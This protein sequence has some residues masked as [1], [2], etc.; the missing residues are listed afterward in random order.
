VDTLIVTPS[1]PEYPAA[2]T[3]VGA[4]ALGFYTVWFET[5]SVPVEFRGNGGAVRN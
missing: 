3:T 5:E 4:S 1:H 2:H